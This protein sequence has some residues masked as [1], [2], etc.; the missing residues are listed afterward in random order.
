MNGPIDFRLDG[1][2]IATVTLDRADLHNAF[3]DA[4]IIGLIGILAKV[5]TDAEISLMVLQGRGKSFSAG[6]DL[7][8]MRR[9]AAYTPDQ[10]LA[11]AQDLARLMHALYTMP[12]PTIALV[13]GGVFGG[14]VGLVACCDI[15]IATTDAKFSLSEVRLGLIPAVISPYVIEAIGA[16]QARRYFQT[17]EIFTA[18]TAHRIGLVHEVVAPEA[19]HATRDALI[20][21][22][23]RGGPQ[24]KASAKALIAEVADRPIDPA[25]IARTARLISERRASAEGREGLAAFLEKRTPSWRSD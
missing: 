7:N 22:L 23:Q 10:N 6:A 20:A 2:G 25:L 8:W 3:D 14:G 21:A 17:G 11:D 12:K 15:A 19:L 5:A 13:Q 9:S 16:R 1:L 4:M 18:E 24:A